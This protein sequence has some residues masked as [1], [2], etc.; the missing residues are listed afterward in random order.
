MTAS[1]Y[2]SERRPTLTVFPV[3]Y[4]ELRVNFS[5]AVD[6]GSAA[7]VNNY[8]L[9]SGLKIVA[10]RVH[11]SAEAGTR[12]PATADGQAT[13]VTLTTDVMNGDLMEVDVLHASGISG[14]LGSPHGPLAS[15][16]F[17][18][19]VASIPQLQK[20]REPGFP[21][22]S[23]FQGLIAT[24]SCQKDGGPDSSHLIDTLGFSF[25]HVERGGPY[26]SLKVVG[27]KHVPGILEEVERLRPQGL[28]PHVLWSGGEIRT[29]DGETRLVDTGFM[30]GSILPAT[31]KKFPPPYRVRIV[32][33]VGE[34]AREIGAKRL[35][36]VIVRFDQVFISEVTEPQLYRDDVRGPEVRRIRFGDES[37]ATM[38]GVLLDS[39][40]RPIKS[41]DRFSSARA[42][43]HQPHFGE[44][45]AIFELDEHLTT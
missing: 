3:G 5:E 22:S 26:N 19:G 40:T 17:V 10:A 34:A 23:R 13:V 43:V 18:S 16:P 41:G 31:P 32:D 20:P 28:S 11:S 33:L 42:I 36:G 39:V 38:G 45:E 35:Q 29:V 4:T 24:L 8:R 37:G 9:A 21:F 2:S 15:R 44:Y 27:Q 25:L 6:S 1:D 30:E 7:N 14:P 12:P